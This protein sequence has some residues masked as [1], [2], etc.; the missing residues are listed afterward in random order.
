MTFRITR[1]KLAGLTAVVVLGGG[2]AIAYAYYNAAGSGTGTGTA[3]SA[4][5]PTVNQ[6]AAVCTDYSAYD[7]TNA[8]T[9]NLFPGSTQTV[10]LTVTNNGK[11]SQQVNDITL[12]SWASNQTGCDPTH[13]PG[14]FTLGTTHYNQDLAAGATGTSVNG[15]ITFNDTNIDQGACQGATITF[16]YAS[17]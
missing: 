17:S 1:K 14:S 12:S 6:A 15:T 5:A 10:H 8:G 11:G 9:C 13:L 7:G 4:T 2:G 16:T 3:G